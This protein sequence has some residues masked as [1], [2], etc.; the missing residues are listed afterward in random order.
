MESNVKSMSFEGNWTGKPHFYTLVIIL[1]LSKS[2]KAPTVHVR[3][4]FQV[5]VQYREA[6]VPFLRIEYE[7]PCDLRVCRVMR[8]SA[9]SCRGMSVQ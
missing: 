6:T 7:V 4:L 3:A 9:V 2:L 8:V 5:S 1:L